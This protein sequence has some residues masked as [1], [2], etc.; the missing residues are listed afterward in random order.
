MNTKD[1][2]IQKNITKFRLS[3]IN[4]V[5]I[6]KIS[7]IIT[8][9]AKIEKCSADTLYKLAKLLN[10]SMEDFIADSTEYRSSFE[11]F[12]SNVCH[13]VHNMGDLDFIIDILE[14]DKIRKLYQKQ[15]Y[16]ESLYLLAMVDYLSRENELPVCADYSDIRKARLQDTIFPASIIAKSVV[17][18]SE[19]IKQDS[20]ERSIPEFKRFN[21]VENDV[22]NVC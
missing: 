15:W 9:K 7:D 18:K 17:S 5:H 16:P 11:N 1:L 20:F 22:R 21:I 3:K 13:M 19:D 14:S 6:S 2:L 10:L 12:K 8:Y 4:G